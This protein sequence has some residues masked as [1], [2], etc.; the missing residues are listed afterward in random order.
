MAQLTLRAQE[1]AQ[2]TD[3]VGACLETVVLFVFSWARRRHKQIVTRAHL[4]HSAVADTKEGII[5]HFRSL[6]WKYLG[7]VVGSL[8]EH[9]AGTVPCMD[10]VANIAHRAAGLGGTE[11]LLKTPLLDAVLACHGR[12][13]TLPSDFESWAPAGP[14]ARCALFV[15]RERHRTRNVD[16]RDLAYKSAHSAD[17]QQFR[18]ELLQFHQE[19]LLAC[20]E[21]TELL[22]RYP[23]RLPLDRPWTVHD[24]QF[25]LCA[26]WRYHQ[27]RAALVE[28][29]DW[30]CVRL[31]SNARAWP[32]NR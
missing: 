15:M 11:F 27:V 18:A 10:S 6:D 26:F 8:G 1:F 30:P 20:P 22:S 24:T 2:H 7:L 5:A 25:V 32:P 16:S 31:Y 13:L 28:R 4:P 23:H 12:G 21:I 17:G 19:L 3:G 14:G 9:L 29:L